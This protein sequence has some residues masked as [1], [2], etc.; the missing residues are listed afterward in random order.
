M[1]GRTAAGR[2]VGRAVIRK[3]GRAVTVEGN[4]EG[5]AQQRGDKKLS[6]LAMLICTAQST[7]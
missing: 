4:G 7:N 5:S 2:T 6:K 1:A 3:L